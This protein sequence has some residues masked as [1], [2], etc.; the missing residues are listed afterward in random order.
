[1]V[2][3]SASYR[4]APVTARKARL[5][6]DMVRGLPVNDAL[7]VLDR[8][9]QRAAMLLRKVVRSA[10]ANA[11]NVAE[12]DPNHLHVAVARVDEGPLKGGH[13][14]WRPA[15]RGRAMP[16]RKRTSHIHVTLATAEPAAAAAT[17]APAAASKDD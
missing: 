5:V 15:A 10:V 14:R 3:F 16:Y 1:M 12:I 13:V 7:V 11:E 6:V 8:A 4:F 9:P 17:P 2:E